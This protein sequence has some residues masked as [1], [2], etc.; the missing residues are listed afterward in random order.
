MD[1]LCVSA[2]AGE[3][4]DVVAHLAGMENFATKAGK[5]LDA[6]SWHT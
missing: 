1:C 4:K 6:F 3:D 2:L 5:T